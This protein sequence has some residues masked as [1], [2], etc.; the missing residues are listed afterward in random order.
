MIALQFTWREL[1]FANWP[2]DADVL[3][4]WLPH[5]LS[6]Q[7]YDG[8]AWL[9]VVPFVNADVRPR[10]LPAWLGVDLP[11][12][13]LRTYVTHHGEPGV[14]FCSLD[15][16]GIASVLGARLTHHLRYFYA[17]VHLQRTNDVV[18]VTSRRRHPGARAAR[19]AAAYRPTGEPFEAEPGSLTEFLTERRRLYAVATDGSVQYTDVAHPRWTLYDVETTIEENTL[20]AG[21]GLPAPEHEPI[22]YYSPGLDV[23]TTRSKRHEGAEPDRA[24]TSHVQHE[25]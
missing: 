19:F 23:V 9:S 4:T 24:G 1:L 5:P 12:V 11:E 15:A 20:F 16:E 2:V 8:R 3:E 21:S 6:V 18:S 22:C 14:Y 10:G 7:C 17:R 13:N 25:Q